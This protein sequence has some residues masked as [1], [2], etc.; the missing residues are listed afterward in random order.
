MEP[1][2]GC[3]ADVLKTNPHDEGLGVFAIADALRYLP[4][5]RRRTVAQLKLRGL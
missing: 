3:A 2:A 5:I 4:T 1:R